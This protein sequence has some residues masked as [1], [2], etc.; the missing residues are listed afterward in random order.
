MSNVEQYIPIDIKDVKLLDWLVDRAIVNRLWNEECSE[1]RSL[2]KQVLTEECPLDD[3]RHEVVEPILYPV[4]VRI[5]EALE[6]SPFGSKN[7]IGQYTHQYTATWARIVKLFEKDSTFLA[8]CAKNLTQNVK[9]D[10]PLFKKQIARATQVKQDSV[11]KQADCSNNITKYE[12]KYREKCAEIGIVGDHVKSELSGLVLDIPYLMSEISRSLGHIQPAISYYQEFVRF[13]INNP[14]MEVCPILTYFVKHGNT[15]VSQWENPGVPMESSDSESSVEVIDPIETQ[16]K[17]GCVYVTTDHHEHIETDPEPT[18]PEV[19]TTFGNESPDDI[20]FG[21]DTIDFGTDIDFG[22]ETVDYGDIDFGDEGGIEIDLLEA[23]EENKNQTL[24]DN[25][26][27][28]NKIIDELYELSAFLSA[29]C[30]EMGRDTESILSEIPD[31]PPEIQTAQLVGVSKMLAAVDSPLNQLTCDKMRHLLLL[32]NSEKYLDRLG[33]NLQSQLR[34]SDKMQETIAELKERVVEAEK[35]YEDVEPKLKRA[36]AVTKELKGC[37]EKHLRDIDFGDEGGIEIDLLEAGEEN[38]NQTLLDNTVTRNK[39]IDELYELSAFLSARCEEMGRD[40]E[41]ILSEI[42]DCPPEIQTAQLVG[43]SKMLA[44]VDSPLNQLTC[45]K[46]RHLLLLKNSEKYLDRLGDNLQSQLRLSDKM[47]ETIAELKERVVEAEKTYEDVEPKLKRAIAVTKELKGCVEKHLS[48]RY[49]GRPVRI[50]GDI[51]TLMVIVD[52]LDNDVKATIPVRPSCKLLPASATVGEACHVPF[53]FL[54]DPVRPTGEGD[55][56]RAIRCT[57]CKSYYNKHCQLIEDVWKCVFCRENNTLLT[58]EVIP[59]SVAT[60][61]TYTILDKGVGSLSQVLIFIVDDFLST[62]EKLHIFNAISRTVSEADEGTRVCMFLMSSVI[63]V[64]MLSRKSPGGIIETEVLS[65]SMSKGL[66]PFLTAHWKDM[67]CEIS[68]SRARL[69]EILGDI[70][71]G[72]M[73]K[74]KAMSGGN[75]PFLRQK[76]VNKG[77][78]KCFGFTFEMLVTFLKLAQPLFIPFFSLGAALSRVKAAVHIYC[79][80][81]AVYAIE[82]LQRMISYCGGS[83]K[84]TRE[85]VNDVRREIESFVD[86]ICGHDCV[87]RL[88]TTHNISIAQVNGETLDSAQFGRR[89]PVLTRDKKFHALFSIPS[90]IN[91]APVYLQCTNSYTEPATSTRITHVTTLRFDCVVD[92]EEIILSLCPDTAFALTLLE[93]VANPEQSVSRS[94]GN[95]YC[96]EISGDAVLPVTWTPSQADAAKTNY[97]FELYITCHNLGIEDTSHARAGKGLL[98]N[99]GCSKQPIRTCYLGHV[100]S[101]QPI[102]D[103]YFLIRSVPG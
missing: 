38:K 88:Q 1:L 92:H 15:A 6:N 70:T 10:V 71:T 27:T 73:R 94:W 24:L 35:T 29:R 74:D 39:I 5:L 43:V 58:G 99:K 97:Q 60:G 46:M 50:M 87:I 20:D 18:L 36:I 19:S 103:Q 84:W 54:F 9:Y 57:A 67:I 69:L 102:R 48:I 14:D 21:I 68:T 44:A 53:G 32:K 55:V 37:V 56:T 65:G 77:D 3:I 72:L 25:T 80:G 64:Y 34:L 41:S 96:D 62:K 33:D 63:N 28:R 79:V 4:S 7:M 100:T 11:K 23:G 47:Q 13:L 31:C 76:R 101:Y 86:N 85:L 91:T 45:D 93:N 16:D 40:T 22:E 81:D 83:L 52:G 66:L 61:E 89:Y 75:N 42:P 30:E 2:I 90:R 78:G 49:K 95:W 8:D 26:V 82:T 59:Q 51:N 98:R 12:A 17:N